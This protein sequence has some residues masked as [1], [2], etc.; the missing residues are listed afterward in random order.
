MAQ[1]ACLALIGSNETHPPKPTPGLLGQVGG[2]PV[3][4][5]SVVLPGVFRLGIGA[6]AAASPSQH[7]T[8]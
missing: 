8:T 2:S 4:K 7:S 5:H 3:N 6:E 1:P